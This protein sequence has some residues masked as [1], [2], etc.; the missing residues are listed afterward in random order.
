MAL[1]DMPSPGKDA[2]SPTRDSDLGHEHSWKSDSLRQRSTGL[3][4]QRSYGSQHSRVSTARSGSVKGS[5]HFPLGLVLACPG[6]CGTAESQ[7]S[8][9]GQGA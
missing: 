7:L 4:S 3:L 5:L 2:L 9:R 8:A 6:G 1:G